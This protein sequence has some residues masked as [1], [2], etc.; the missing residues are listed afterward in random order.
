MRILHL[1][2]RLTDRGGAYTW[3]HGILEGLSGDHEVRLAVGE[4]DLT[5]RV[6]CPVDVRPGLESRTESAVD[7]DGLV[8]RFAPDV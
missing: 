8:R 2:D 1:A 5:L 4:A 6:G 3:L 7:L